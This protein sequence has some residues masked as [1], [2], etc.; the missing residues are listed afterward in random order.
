MTRKHV[1]H[2]L[3]LHQLEPIERYL[4]FLTGQRRSGASA[5]GGI[6]VQATPRAQRFEGG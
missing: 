4:R 1:K 5:F 2:I 6:G 3:D